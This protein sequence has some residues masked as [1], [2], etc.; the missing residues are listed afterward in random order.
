MAS[1]AYVSVY[2]V[3]YDFTFNWCVVYTALNERFQ[4]VYSVKRYT[5]VT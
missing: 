3:I 4:M 2:N 5:D 1:I